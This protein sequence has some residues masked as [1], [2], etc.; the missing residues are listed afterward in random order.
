MG[1]VE[2]QISYLNGWPKGYLQNGI[3]ASDKP[4]DGCAQD[5]LL[6]L[7]GSAPSGEVVLG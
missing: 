1:W 6:P 7:L 5:F 4:E 3:N 2:R